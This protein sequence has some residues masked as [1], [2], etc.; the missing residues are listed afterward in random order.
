LAAAS[1]KFYNFCDDAS[2]EQ[3]ATC[4]NAVIRVI[5]GLRPAME[6]Q[7]PKDEKKSQSGLYGDYGG[8]QR[9]PNLLRSDVTTSCTQRSRRKIAS[10]FV[11][12]FKYPSIS[13]TQIVKRV[14]D[15]RL[16]DGAES[17]FWPRCLLF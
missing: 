11:S 14:I 8:A 12:T 17:F 15:Y 4:C 13:G 2:V 1:I 7:Y 16:T 9:K 3:P 5:Y 6:T 10:G